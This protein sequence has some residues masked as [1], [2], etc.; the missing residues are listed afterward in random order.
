MHL[1][2][3]QWVFY[4][5]VSN[6]AGFSTRLA[7]LAFALNADNGTNG[8]RVFQVQGIGIRMIEVPK[9]LRWHD[10]LGADGADLSVDGYQTPQFRRTGDEVCLRGTLS[11]QLH[12]GNTQVILPEGFRPPGKLAFNRVSYDSYWTS[13]THAYEHTYFTQINAA[14]VL[15][16]KHHAGHSSYSSKG[17][18]RTAIHDTHLN[19]I[20]F[21]ITP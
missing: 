21:S 3:Q 7:R 13:G 5:S 12:D 20:C 1:I 14:G 9:D 6:H 11:L 19:G 10:L 15:K 2:I 8:N 4:F 16:N 17:N 18:L